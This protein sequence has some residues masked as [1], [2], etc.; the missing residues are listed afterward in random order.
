VI[1]VGVRAGRIGHRSL[2]P[3]RGTAKPGMILSMEDWCYELDH[4][5]VEVADSRL[6]APVLTHLGGR[7]WRLEQDYAYRDGTTTITVPAGFRFDLS[8]VPRVLWWLIAPF[9]LSIAAP[10][11]HDFLYRNRGMPPAG[12]VEPPRTYTR[13]EV[14]RMFRTIMRKEGVPAWRRAIGYAAVRLFGGAD[15]RS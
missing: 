1:G 7:Q 10:L 3:W 15:W 4:D 13:S 2:Q 5:A 8:S 14:D 12:A 6:S 11:L 9:E